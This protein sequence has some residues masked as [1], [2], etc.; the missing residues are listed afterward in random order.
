MENWIDVISIPVEERS[1][2]KERSNKQ[3]IHSNNLK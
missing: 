1:S 2:I 3:F